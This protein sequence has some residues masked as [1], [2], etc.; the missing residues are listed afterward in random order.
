LSELTLTDLEVDGGSGRTQVVLPEGNFD[1]LYEVGSGVTTLTL[2]DFGRQT[3]HIDGGSGRLTVLVPLSLEARITVQDGGSGGL[4]L[5]DQ[6][7]E[8][9]QG[10]QDDEGVWQTAGY[11]DSVNRADLFLD[12]GSG[13]MIVERQ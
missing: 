11:Q 9:I 6:A 4:Q 12:I 8:L 7:F 2:P 5:A 10:G 13:S 1:V 3:I